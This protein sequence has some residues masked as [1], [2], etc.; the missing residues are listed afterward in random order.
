[1]WTKSWILGEISL[2]KCSCIIVYYRRFIVDIVQSDIYQNTVLPCY[3]T[4]RYN[5]VSDVTL[6]L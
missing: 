6:S 3:N 1:M 2:C 4:M 5:T